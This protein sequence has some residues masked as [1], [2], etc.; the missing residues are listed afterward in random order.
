MQAAM[1]CI[2]CSTGRASGSAAAAAAAASTSG[3]C[4]ADCTFTDAVSCRLT[5]CWLGRHSLQPAAIAQVLQARLLKR[6]CPG[7]LAHPALC[8]CSP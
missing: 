4:P 5:E 2:T 6:G 8:C 1:A 3:D 7:T